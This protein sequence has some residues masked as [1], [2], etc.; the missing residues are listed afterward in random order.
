MARLF[1]ALKKAINPETP[2]IP[3]HL[4][5]QHYPLLQDSEA[6]EEESPGQESLARILDPVH[7]PCRSKIG[8]TPLL[9]GPLVLWWSGEGL[10]L[11]LQLS[12]SVTGPGGKPWH[13]D[14]SGTEGAVRVP[15]G[16]TV[17]C[18]LGARGRAERGNPPGSQGQPS[19]PPSVS[20]GRRSCDCS[21]ASVSHP[22]PRR[23]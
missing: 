2:C 13:P 18:L 21:Q 6:R 22:A 8:L 1:W 19:H 11:P 4:A 15:P 12:V 17:L 9:T 14:V 16:G 23:Y 7:R 5:T 3:S 10:A 20:S